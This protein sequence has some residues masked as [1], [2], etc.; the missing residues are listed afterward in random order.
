MV[1]S[2]HVLRNLL[3][4]R[5]AFR[6]IRVGEQG[7]MQIIKNVTCCFIR[8]G[9]TRSSSGSARRKARLAIS[10][11]SR[12]MG[13]TV[14]FLGAVRERIGRLEVICQEVQPPRCLSVARLVQEHGPRF[15]MAEL[16]RLLAA[17]LRAAQGREGA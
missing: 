4:C 1:H 12:T 3:A 17:D 2:Q 6:R 7:G 13:S 14:I 9:A 8:G 16:L 10:G 15:P 11:M 5:L